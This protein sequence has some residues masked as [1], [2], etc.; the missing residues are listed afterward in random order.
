MCSFLFFSKLSETFS[1]NVLSRVRV[2]VFLV[3]QGER[4][5]WGGHQSGTS[6]S[7]TI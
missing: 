2:T 1:S 3:P 7:D 6:V 5:M 4:E